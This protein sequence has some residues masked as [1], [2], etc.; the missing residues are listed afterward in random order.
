MPAS[1]QPYMLGAELFRMFQQ[2]NGFY[3]YEQ[4]LHIFPLGSDVTNT[5]TLEEWNSD[6]LWRSAY[7]GLTEGLLFFAEDVFGD[8]F[9][10]SRLH[11]GIFHFDGEHGSTDF[12]AASI[13]GWADLMLRD[14]EVQTGWTLAHEWQNKNGA[15]G[16]GQRLQPK[17][18]FA[19]GGE[20]VLENLWAGDAVKGMLFKGEVS[21]KIRNLRPGTEVHFR[22]KG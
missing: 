9:C 19:Y 8:Q 16:L 6:T 3:V 20:Y 4:A 15:L 13:E 18:P 1:W 10:L 11:S 21:L 22:V 14:Y 5:M 12:V 7:D 2:K 17:I